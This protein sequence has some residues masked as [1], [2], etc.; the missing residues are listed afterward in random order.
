MKI[1]LTISFEISSED[2]R[3]NLIFIDWEEVVEKV[4]LKK[5]FEPWD[6]VTMLSIIYRT[7]D[8]YLD[9]EEQS[10]IRYTSNNSY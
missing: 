6:K 10:K 3:N 8:M 2:G 9:S 7:V 5:S 4:R 1:L